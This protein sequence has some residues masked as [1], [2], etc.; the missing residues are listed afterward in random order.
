[1]LKHPTGYYSFC[2]LTKSMTKN[3]RLTLNPIVFLCALPIIYGTIISLCRESKKCLAHIKRHENE[4]I[5]T[6]MSNNENGTYMCYEIR[7]CIFSG[8]VKN[9]V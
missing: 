9:D 4:A 2:V 7:V 5:I 8:K 1:M 6:L 3:N